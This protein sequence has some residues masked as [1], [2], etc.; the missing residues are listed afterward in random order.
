MTREEIQDA[1]DAFNW[2]AAQYGGDNDRIIVAIL[3][4]MQRDAARLLELQS[5][6][7]TQLLIEKASRE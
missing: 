3:N 1:R 7:M 4:A 5:E 2:V 6:R